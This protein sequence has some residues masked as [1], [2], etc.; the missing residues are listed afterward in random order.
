MKILLAD[1]DLVTSEIIKEQLQQWGYEVIC[2]YNG[3]DAWEALQAKEAPRLVILDWQMPGLT[4]LEIC[5][6][7]RSRTSGSYVYV[8]LLTSLADKSDLIQGMEAG[9]DDFLTKPYN[10]HEL[11]VRLHA[12]KRI[13]ALEEELLTTLEQTRRLVV[14]DA[15]AY[16][17]DLLTSREIDILRLVALGSTNEDIALIFHLGPD[18]VIAHMNNIMDKLGAKSKEEAATIA[19]NKGLIP[20]RTH[21]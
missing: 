17:N 19:L 4:G 2:K 14:K 16:S 18:W 9:A 8:V 7:L 15:S 1:D 21:V 3:V 11:R 5:K 13:V 20:Q 10:A 6:K 12:G